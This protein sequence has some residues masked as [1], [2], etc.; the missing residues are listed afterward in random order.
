[1]KIYVAGKFAEPEVVRQCHHDLK[2]EGHTITFD[3]TANEYHEGPVTHE[4]AQRFACL[5]RDGAAQA[6]VLVALLTD[7]TYAYRGTF[8]ELTA[9]EEN[10]ARVIIVSPVGSDWDTSHYASTNVFYHR[11]EYIHVQT[12]EEAKELIATLSLT[13]R[14][15]S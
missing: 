4:Q 15:K 8:C 3:W 14:I 5:D 7:P 9:A 10:G 1:M 13:G 2:A 6:D 11:P 12:W